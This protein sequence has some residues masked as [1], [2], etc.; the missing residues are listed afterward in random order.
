MANLTT[1]ATD[2][3]Q[4]FGYG[5]VVLGLFINAVGVPIPSELILPLAGLGIHQGKLQVLP[6]ILLAI[7]AQVAG[8]GVSYAIARFGGTEL[9]ERYGKYI[10]IR[11]H[12]LQLTERA[13]AKYGGRLVLIGGCLPALHGY[14]GY[15]AGLAKMK[16]GRFMGAATVGTTIWTIA[17]VSLGYF[18]SSHIN[19]IASGLSHF[20]ILIVILAVAVVIWWVSRQR[21]IND[22]ATD[23]TA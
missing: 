12:E 14:V 21:R 6:L 20:G 13:F 22:T 15:P 16:F 4:Q 2:L 5:G 23:H 18:L 9:I 11:Q 8:L 17:L 19:S 3:I 10:L 1:V 7:C